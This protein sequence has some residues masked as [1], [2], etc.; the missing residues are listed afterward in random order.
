MNKTKSIKPHFQTE[1]WHFEIKPPT[2]TKHA[3]DVTAAHYHAVSVCSLIDVEIPH[4]YAK[5]HMCGSMYSSAI[6]SAARVLDFPG[7]ELKIE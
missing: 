3:A 5:A 1:I 4:F 7:R 2:T 6:Y